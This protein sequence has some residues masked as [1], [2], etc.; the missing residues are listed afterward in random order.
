VPRLL[1][2]ARWHRYTLSRLGLVRSTVDPGGSVYPRRP[3]PYPLYP[4]VGGVVRGATGR[5]DELADCSASQG[6]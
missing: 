6:H 5:A 1:P 3:F 2:Q 4:A